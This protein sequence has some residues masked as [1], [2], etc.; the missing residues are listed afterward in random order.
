MIREARED[1]V[2]KIP[3]RDGQEGTQTIPITKGTQASKSISELPSVPDPL[4]ARLL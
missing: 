3:N 1:A 4:S 2:L